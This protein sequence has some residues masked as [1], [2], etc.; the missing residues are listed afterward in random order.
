MHGQDGKQENF[1]KD[2][3]K[4]SVIA[5]VIVIPIRFFVAQPFIVSGASMLPTFDSGQYL[6]VDQLSYYF[7]EPKR[8]E[9]IIFKYPKDP[10]KYF[11]K[12]VVGLPGETIRIEGKNIYV[13]NEDHPSGFLLEEPYLEAEN[14]QPSSLTIT[15]SGDQYFVLG[16]NRRASSDSRIWGPL[17]EDLVVGRAFLRLLPINQSGILPGDHRTP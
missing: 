14:V 13:E 4:F 17:S 11:I 15:L 7:H 6:I 1:F 16:D 9:V 3:I 2:I 12:R 8:G 10:S 5:L